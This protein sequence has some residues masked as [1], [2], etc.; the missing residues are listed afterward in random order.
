V[1]LTALLKAVGQDLQRARLDRKWKPTDVERAGGPSYKT[2]QAIE[3]GEPGHIE[4]LDKC[5]KALQLSI[6]DVLYSVLASKETPLS[7]E[8]ALLVRR[9]NET[10]IAGRQ[11]LLAMANALPPVPGDAGVASKPRAPR[12]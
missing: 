4:S 5:A 8:A 10:T 11:A 3:D 1:D 9:F 7:P 12:R 6:V 2:V